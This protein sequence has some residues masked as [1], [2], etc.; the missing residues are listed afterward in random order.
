MVYLPQT[1]A[2]TI[3]AIGG[4][5][6]NLGDR[7]TRGVTVDD[8]VNEIRKLGD[9]EEW[10]RTGEYLISPE[11]TADLVVLINGTLAGAPRPGGPVLYP[12]R[13]SSS[14]AYSVVIEARLRPGTF[15]ASDAAHFR[16]A[17]KQLYEMIRTDPQLAARLEAQYPGITQHVTPGPRGGFADTPPP[18]FSWHHHP[19]Q[20]GV[21]QL[22][23]RDHHQ[24]AGPVQQ[25]LHPE[26]KGG[27]ENWG[28]GRKRP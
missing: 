27:R 7:G 9:P 24:A 3:G 6:V 16:Q 17:N 1:I 8:T 11:G 21:I 15:T 5:I 13:P 25:S 14:P 26:Q 22:V 28:G 12:G 20:P 4:Y 23:P 10:K 2:H 19:K 18:G